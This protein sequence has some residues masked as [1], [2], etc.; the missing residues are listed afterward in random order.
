MAADTDDAETLYAWPTCTACG[1]PRA[2]LCPY[3]GTAGHEFSAAYGVEAEPDGDP[4]RIPVVCPTCD[5]AFWTR[6]HPDCA[7]C[8]SRNPAEGPST[9]PAGEPGKALARPRPNADRIAVGLPI[10]KTKRGGLLGK[11]CGCGPRIVTEADDADTSGGCCR[12]AP[13]RPAGAN[14]VSISPAGSFRPETI[15]TDAD[16]PTCS[17][18]ASCSDDAGDELSADEPRAAR[19]GRDADGEPLKTPAQLEFEREIARR[20]TVLI[21]AMLACGAV[22]CAYLLWLANAA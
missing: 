2:T 6:F 5:E 11:S 13:A 14:L 17:D 15:P 7:W 22:I 8:G 9:A 1:K 19:P 12:T 3:C 16:A 21:G 4:H 10:R 20:A 18:D